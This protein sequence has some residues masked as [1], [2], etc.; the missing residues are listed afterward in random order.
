MRGNI[1]IMGIPGLW[2]EVKGFMGITQP[3]SNLVLFQ[4]KYVGVD[5]SIWSNQALHN[6]NSKREIAINFV[7]SPPVEILTIISAYLD[8]LKEFYDGFGIIL[9]LIYDGSRNPLKKNDE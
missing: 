5:S 3:K 6:K 1:I 8:G 2:K 7:L 4:G 9:P